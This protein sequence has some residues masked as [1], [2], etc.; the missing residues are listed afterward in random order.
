[1]TM[2]EP[3]ARV[4][5]PVAEHDGPCEVPWGF[6]PADDH[7]LALGIYTTRDKADEVAAEKRFDAG[8]PP[9]EPGDPELPDNA[10]VNFRVSPSCPLSSAD[11]ALHPEPPQQPGS[12]RLSEPP[13]LPHHSEEVVGEPSPRLLRMHLGNAAPGD[14]Q[15]P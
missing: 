2:Q 13:L 5:Y 3:V 6:T 9:S 4:L 7:D 11:G 10:F 8:A 12:R 1:M 15:P 14:L